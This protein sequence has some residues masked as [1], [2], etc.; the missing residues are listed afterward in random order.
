MASKRK[1]AKD[2]RKELE[3]VSNQKAALEA[4]IIE[5][6]RNLCSQYP[7]IIIATNVRDNNDNLTTKSFIQMENLHVITALSLIE[8]IEREL[9]E[10]HPHKQTKMF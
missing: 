2:Y 3:E 8:G 1:T 10:K 4:R 5:R 9:A 7:D 6:A